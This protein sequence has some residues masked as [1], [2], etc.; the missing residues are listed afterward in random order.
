MLPLNIHIFFFLVS[1][2]LLAF[3]EDGLAVVIYAL[4]AAVV[5]LL[6]WARREQRAGRINWCHPVPVFALGYCI[7]YY[8]LPFCYL[9][10]F[11]LSYYS[12]FVVFSPQKIP[13]CVLLA[14]MGLSAFFCGEQVFHNRRSPVSAAPDPG[15][16]V[17]DPLLPQYFRRIR[18]INTALLL[19]TLA[20]YALYISSMG[21]TSYLGFSYGDTSRVTGAFTT[22]LALLYTVLLYLCV[23]LEIVRLI[24]IRPASLKEYLRAWDKRVLAVLAI[25]IVPY[26]LS[27]D[28]GS[29]L[30]PLSLIMA[31]Y[32]VLVKPLRFRHAVIAVVAMAFLLVVIGDTRGRGDVTLSQALST[33]LDSVA[34]PAEWPT[35]ELANSFGTFNIATTYFPEKYGYSNGEKILYNFAALVPLS[36]FFTEVEE[37]N[38]QNNY[39]FTSTLFFTNILTEGTFSSGSGTSS[40]ADAYMDFGPYGLPVILFLWGVFMAWISRRASG[41]SS[42]IFVFLYVYYSYYGIYVNRSSFFFGWNNF[43][44]V[45]IGFYAINRLYLNRYLRVQYQ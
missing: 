26:V 14:A 12:N 7:V 38:K 44:W 20:F 35:M 24:K 43:I 22:Y 13:Y 16:G 28:R 27:G 32:F 6:V 37:K 2:V 31:P 8:Q 1:W 40:L 3:E 19:L 10:E 34:N 45:L 39:V 17:D 23:L 29:Y 33:R 36:S 9:G 18:R 4:C 42:A 30:Q 41:A 11:N 15:L 21:I 25:T 5:E